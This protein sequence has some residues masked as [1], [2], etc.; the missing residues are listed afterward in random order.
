MPARN[1]SDSAICR[2]GALLNFFHFFSTTYRGFGLKVFEKCPPLTTDFIS[3]YLYLLNKKILPT[4]IF[5]T[6]LLCSFE[7]EFKMEK[8]YVHYI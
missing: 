7:I 3:R 5:V 4:Y 2:G 1:P 8:T 6:Y